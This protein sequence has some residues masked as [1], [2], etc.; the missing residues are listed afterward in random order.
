MLKNEDIFLASCRITPGSSIIC[1]K[2]LLKRAIDEYNEASRLSDKMQQFEEYERLDW[3]TSNMRL[4]KDY[5]Q[6]LE[7]NIRK[8]ESVSVFGEFQKH[9]DLYFDLS[10]VRSEF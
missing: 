4:E 2:I 5:Y 6:L 3:L 9:M 10:G 1:K 8:G 7:E